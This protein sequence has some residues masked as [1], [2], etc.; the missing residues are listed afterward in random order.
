MRAPG[1]EPH[2]ESFKDSLINY[3]HPD[4]DTAVW[5]PKDRP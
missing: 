1:S 4:R 5:P 3:Q 2:I